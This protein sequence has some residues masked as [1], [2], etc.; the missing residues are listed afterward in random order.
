MSP[1]IKKVCAGCDHWDIDI[2]APQKIEM[3]PVLGQWR[4]YNDSCQ[5]WAES[6][7]FALAQKSISKKV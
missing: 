7:C 6:T 4:A 2:K 1:K 3:C 5:F